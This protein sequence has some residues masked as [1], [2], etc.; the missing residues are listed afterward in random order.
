M[1]FFIALYKLYKDLISGS[2]ISQPQSQEAGSASLL[3]A[4]SVH[5]FLRHPHLKPLE[6][7]FRD[8]RK[9]I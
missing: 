5:Y 9:L 2:E 8:R 3:L 4:L 1:E 7:G 6:T